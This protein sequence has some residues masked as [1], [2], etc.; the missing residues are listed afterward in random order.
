MNASAEHAKPSSVANCSGRYEK[1][2]IASKLKR[3]I[4]RSVY[5]VRPAAAR[6]ALERDRGLREADP[7]AHPAQEA[8]ALAHR[9]QRV[10]RARDPSAGSR[11]TRA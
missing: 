4:R 6:L 10:E 5:L 9:Q 1:L 8:V 7:D 11:R 2:V 3:S